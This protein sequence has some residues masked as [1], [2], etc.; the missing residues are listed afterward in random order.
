MAGYWSDRRP[1]DAGIVLG[2]G[3]GSLE[4]LRERLAVLRRTIDNADG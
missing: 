2:L 3:T 4:R 1:R